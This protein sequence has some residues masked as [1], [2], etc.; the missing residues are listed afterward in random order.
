MKYSDDRVSER[1]GVLRGLSACG[2]KGEATLRYE[3]D[4]AN[5]SVINAA[6]DGRVKC[7]HFIYSYIYININLVAPRKI[8]ITY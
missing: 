5:F 2:R 6:D 7:L 1:A 8:S 4:C 3:W